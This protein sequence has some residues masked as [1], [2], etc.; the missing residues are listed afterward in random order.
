MSAGFSFSK[1]VA[2]H[3]TLRSNIK[4]SHLLD[5]QIVKASIKFKKPE[6]INR[7][8]L[9]LPIIFDYISY[10]ISTSTRIQFLNVP[11]LVS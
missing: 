1:R 9:F 4:L 8:A 3:S 2:E 6:A 7:E 5:L 11:R 10:I